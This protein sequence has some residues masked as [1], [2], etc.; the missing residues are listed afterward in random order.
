MLIFPGKQ[1]K[2]PI[3]PILVEHHTG[4]PNQKNEITYILI[5]KEKNKTVS[6]LYGHNCLCGKSKESISF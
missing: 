1:G 2:G 6:I 4:I 5:G 3:L